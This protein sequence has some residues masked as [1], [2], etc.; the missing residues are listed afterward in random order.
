MKKILF[1]LLV[2]PGFLLTG[3]INGKYND[4]ANSA[5]VI[6]YGGTS[7][8]ITTAVQ[9]TKMGKSVLIVCPDSHLGGLST[10][11]LETRG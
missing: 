10:P 9:V 2:I 11:I 1:G 5:D 6:I 8:A 7:A 3:C 4:S